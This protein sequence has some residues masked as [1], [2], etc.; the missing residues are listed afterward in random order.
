MTKCDLCPAPAQTNLDD[1]RLCA[2]CA[3]QVIAPDGQLCDQCGDPLTAADVAGGETICLACEA[4]HIARR[5][6]AAGRSP[7]LAYVRFRLDGSDT[8]ESPR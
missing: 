5:A 7:L 4:E 8:S 1:L 6:E 3:N 2:K